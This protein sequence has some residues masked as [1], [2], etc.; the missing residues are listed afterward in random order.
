MKASE[1]LTDAIKGSASMMCPTCELFLD[2]HLLETDAELEVSIAEVLGNKS[3]LSWNYRQT[4]FI[5]KVA[6]KLHKTIYV[7]SVLYV[8]QSAVI[9]WA[10]TKDTMQWKSDYEL[11]QKWISDPDLI[12][13]SIPKVS[14]TQQMHSREISMQK[15]MLTISWCSRHTVVETGSSWHSWSLRSIWDF[16]PTH[17]CYSKEGILKAEESTK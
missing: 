15:S 4:I 7:I 10:T 2:Q 9:P 1:N 6:G 3:I 17:F 13:A 14:L 11:R 12:R 5:Q 16:Y 8:I